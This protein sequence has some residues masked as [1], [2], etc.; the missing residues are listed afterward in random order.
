[1]SYQ[2]VQI[3]IKNKL[4]NM[5]VLHETNFLSL[6][7][8]SLAH[9]YGSKTLSNHGLI[10]LKRFVSQLVANYVISFVISLYL[11]LHACVQTSDGTATKI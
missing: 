5:S 2:S 1:M 7:N 8:P 6:I 10:R 3:L 9:V 4:Q 11:I